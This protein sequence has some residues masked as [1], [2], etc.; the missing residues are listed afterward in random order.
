LETKKELPDGSLV[1]A[2]TAIDHPSYPVT[3]AYV[4]AQLKAG[5]WHVRPMGPDLSLVR[6]FSFFQPNLATY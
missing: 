3:P 1:L 2:T 5:G 4:R 6:H